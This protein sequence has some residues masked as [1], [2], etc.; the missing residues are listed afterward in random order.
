MHNGLLTQAEGLLTKVQATGGAQQADWVKT[1][2]LGTLVT[3]ATPYPLQP[4]TLPLG[5]GEC[6]TCGFTGHMGRRGRSTFG[7]TRP[8]T[9]TNR[10]AMPLAHKFLD[11]HETQQIYI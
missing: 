7:A 5:P 3:E 11:K 4:G 2:G 8:S 1:H 9:H 10:H 6:F